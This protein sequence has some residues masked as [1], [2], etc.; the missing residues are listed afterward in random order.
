MFGFWLSGLPR[1]SWPTISTR[2]YTQTRRADTTEQTRQIILGAVTS[3]FREAGC[4]EP[5]MTRIAERA[6]CSTR[7]VIRHFGSKEGLIEATIASSPTTIERHQVQPGDIV[8]TIGDLIDRYE[9]VGD[10]HF[11]WIVCG[12]RHPLARQIS[13]TWDRTH[14]R[15][16]DA[17]FAID[18]DLLPPTERRARRATLATVTDVSV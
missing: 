11:R 5:P 15:W 2:T 6:A 10:D 14:Q 17:T 9:I 4:V 7:S 1:L 13:E 3:L 16:V 8:A 18:L 12:E